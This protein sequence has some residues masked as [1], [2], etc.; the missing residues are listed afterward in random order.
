M[1]RCLTRI[2][3]SEDTTYD[4]S[5]REHIEFDAEL[6]AEGR[7]WPAAAETMIGLK[8]LDNL[9]FCIT[10][11]IRHGVRGDLIATG[12][13]RGGATVF[14]RAVLAAYSDTSRTV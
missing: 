6:R 2:V 14:M 4:P 10:D 12:V 8:R 3:F 5:S 9:E 1:K 7:D 13:W 11:V